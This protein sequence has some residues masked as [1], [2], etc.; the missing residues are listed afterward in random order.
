MGV[1]TSGYLPLLC[2]W[3]QPW[4]LTMACSLGFSLLFCKMGGKPSPLHQA[5][6]NWYVVGPLKDHE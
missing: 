3:L 4:T 1:R 5:Y 6:P 2:H